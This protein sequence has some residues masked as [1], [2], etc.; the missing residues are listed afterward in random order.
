MGRLITEQSE[1]HWFNVLADEL[2]VSW[3]FASGLFVSEPSALWQGMLVIACCDWATLLSLLMLSFM[4]PLLMSPPI[5][6]VLC[7]REV[8]IRN[9][10]TR[11]LSRRDL[12]FER[13]FICL[14]DTIPRFSSTDRSFKS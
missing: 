7:A 8:F 3:L 9:T 13:V 6:Q 14:S 1:Q 5:W 2:P 11:M 10:I 12:C 4:V